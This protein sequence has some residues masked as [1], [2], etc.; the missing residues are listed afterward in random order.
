MKIFSMFGVLE[1]WLHRVFT[2]KFRE[3]VQKYTPDIKLNLT[4][5]IVIYGLSIMDGLTLAEIGQ[6]LVGI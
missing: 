6:C 2:S 5:S 4:D 3:Q 1:N